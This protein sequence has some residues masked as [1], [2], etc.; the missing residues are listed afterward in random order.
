MVVNKFKIKESGETE[1]KEDA[2]ENTTAGENWFLFE[3]GW[4]KSFDNQLLVIANLSSII[5]NVFGCFF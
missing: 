1:G 4:W 2:N 5:R 3:N